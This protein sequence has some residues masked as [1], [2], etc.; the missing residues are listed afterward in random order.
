[1]TYEK[2]PDKYRAPETGSV[3]DEAKPLTEAQFKK[4]KKE[5]DE[6]AYSFNVYKFK[7]FYNKWKR[8]GV[9]DAPLPPDEVIEIAMRKMILAMKNPKP[10]KLAEA[11]A[12]LAEHN[13][14]EEV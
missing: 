9:Y 14:S 12:W 5:R 7:A 11:K 10:A 3:A 4:W 2:T 6:A 13:L 1:M 8:K